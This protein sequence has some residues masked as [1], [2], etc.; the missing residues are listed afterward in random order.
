MST[1][2]QSADEELVEFAERTRPALSRHVLEVF[3]VRPLTQDQASLAVLVVELE[4]QLLVIREDPNS[5][6]ISSSNSS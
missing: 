6:A 3:A 2:T 1:V 4:P 5:F